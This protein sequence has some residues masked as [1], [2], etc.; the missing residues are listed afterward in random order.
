MKSEKSDAKRKNSPSRPNIY[1]R[2]SVTPFVQRVSWGE[3]MRVDLGKRYVEEFL[4]G[5]DF[6]GGGAGDFGLCLDK[7]AV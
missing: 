4:S 5:D 2:D 1:F 7:R 3:T 6:A